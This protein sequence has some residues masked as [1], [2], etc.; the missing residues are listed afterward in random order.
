MSTDNNEQQAIEQHANLHIPPADPERS[1]RVIVFAPCWPIRFDLTSKKRAYGA[2]NDSPLVPLS[3]TAPMP[4]CAMEPL[5]CVAAPHESQ[6][7]GIAASWAQEKGVIEIYVI[8][9][10]YD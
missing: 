8:E 2:L 10:M 5:S 9:E 4:D 6:R 3:T 7:R 1:N